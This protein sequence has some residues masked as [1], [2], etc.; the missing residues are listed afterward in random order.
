MVMDDLLKALE[1]VR[2]KK[3]ALDAAKTAV[4]AASEAHEQAVSHAQGLHDHFNDSVSD[5]LPSVRPRVR[6][7]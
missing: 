6:T 5:L 2:D 3:A 4:I 7:A 1:D